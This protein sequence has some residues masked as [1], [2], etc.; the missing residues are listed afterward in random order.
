MRKLRILRLQLDFPNANDEVP[1]LPY[2]TPY[3]RMLEEHAHTIAHHIPWLDEVSF[4][5]YLNDD[6]AWLRWKVGAEANLKACNYF[7]DDCS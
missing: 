5:H 3:M 6:A 7:H 4:L 1:D 2:A